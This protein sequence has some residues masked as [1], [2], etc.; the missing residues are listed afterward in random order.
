MLCQ[1]KLWE[2]TRVKFFS[3]KSKKCYGRTNVIVGL[4]KTKFIAFMGFN[5]AYT[6]SL[7]NI[8]VE[9]SLIKEL[10]LE[11]ILIIDN[12]SFYK[13]RKTTHFIKSVECM[14][15]FYLA[16]HQISIQ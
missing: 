13:S 3:K 15:M 2:S 9:R 12:A 7:L 10:K 6:R 5:E 11:K 1:D 14:L 8:W 16:T 4:V